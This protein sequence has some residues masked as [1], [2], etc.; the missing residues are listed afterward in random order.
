MVLQVWAEDPA[1]P[2]A[3]VGRRQQWDPA[4]QGVVGR[5]AGRSLGAPTQE[6][7]RSPLGQL[8]PLGR[9]MGWSFGPGGG[10]GA[11][12]VPEAADPSP[13]LGWTLGW[14]PL[15]PLVCP[16]NSTTPPPPTRP[17]SPRLWPF[18]CAKVGGVGCARVRLVSPNLHKSK[19]QHMV[20]RASV[21]QERA[22]RLWRSHPRG[23][24]DWPSPVSRLPQQDT[25]N[26]QTDSLEPGTAPTPPSSLRHILGPSVSTHGVEHGGGS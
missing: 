10:P 3:Q 6:R 2:G 19:Q 4:Q 5:G 7:Q 25:G 8:A 15:R 21:C 16:S 26:P 12:T 1:F 13:L 24:G 18:C 14:N 23:L 11:G 17:S 20:S 22:G 9:R